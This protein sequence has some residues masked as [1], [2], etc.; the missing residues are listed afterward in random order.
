MQEMN[1]NILITTQ[2]AISSCLCCSCSSFFPVASYGGEVSTWKAPT[3]LHPKAFIWEYENWIESR[4][5]MIRTIDSV[6][7]RLKTN[8]RDIKQAINDFQNPARSVL[9]K[10][11]L[12]LSDGT[13]EADNKLKRFSLNTNEA[14]W[15]SGKLSPTHPLYKIPTTINLGAMYRWR[16][17]LLDSSVEFNSL[18]P[19]RINLSAKMLFE[20]QRTS[21]SDGK[22]VNI[23]FNEIELQNVGDNVR[24]DLNK[25]YYKYLKNRYDFEVT[26]TSFGGLNEK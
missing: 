23:E 9:N 16:I 17:D 20:M 2:L 5:N 1:K 8:D 18:I 6:F 4:R 22:W 26:S 13:V 15:D 12:R 19:N 14:M 25:A 3:E 24:K 7:A 10:Y 21:S 11:R